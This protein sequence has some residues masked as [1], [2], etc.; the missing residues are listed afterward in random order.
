MKSKITVLFLSLFTVVFISCQNEIAEITQ[1]PQDEVLKAD[2]NVA[3]LMQRTTAKDGSKDN[4]IDN[5]SCLSV[6]LPITVEVRGL[7][8]IVD[9]EEDFDTIEALFDEFDNDIDDLDIF[10]PIVI[11]LSDFTEI[12]IENFDQLENYIN[13]C[14]NENEI[15]DDIECLD[16]VYPITA[17]IFDSENQLTETITVENDEDLYKF[18]DDIEEYIVVQIN[19]PMSV[20]LYNGTEKVINNM[21]EL[22]TIIEESDNMCDE[23]DDNDYDDDDCLDCTN[24][25]ITDLL[26]SCSWTVDKIEINSEENAEQYSNFLF[27]FLENGTLI[28]ESG[29][30]EIIGSW[31]IDNS[32][33]G[34]LVKLSFENPNFS[35]FSFDWILYEIEQNNEIDLRIGD[36]RLELE[37][38]C[39]DDKIE[40]VEV[41]NE[42][43]W[44]VAKFIDNDENKTSIYND[45]VLDFKENSTVVAYKG[46]DVV[47]GTWA[48]IYDSGKLKLE[49]NFGETVPFN[50]FNEDWLAV[51][52]Q[53]LRVE[54]NN[55]D[56]LGNEESNLVFERI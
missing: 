56:S 5:A 3:V 54:V 37:K 10:F 31:E 43:T 27:T 19:F 14:E 23:D 9:S 34:I 20:V 24:E 35:V 2:T 15:D 4:I 48:V 28:A 32:D 45:F 26:I 22:E 29:G 40:L 52:I 12:T 36:N 42:G 38:L 49:L 11:V 13:E 55:L 25:Q 47:E 41:L 21:D 30:S 33:T 6:Q 17:S 46:N 8:I 1:A 53:N 7:E 51:D 44:L 39:I 50:E 18:I 16:F